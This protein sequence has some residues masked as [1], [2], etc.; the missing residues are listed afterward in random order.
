MIA[1]N[2]IRV[3]DILIKVR[4]AQY[5]CKELPMLLIYL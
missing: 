5:A 1:Y 3:P 2:K 4:N